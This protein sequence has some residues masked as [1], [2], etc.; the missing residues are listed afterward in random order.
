MT[1]ANPPSPAGDRR[2][3]RDVAK[4]IDRRRMRRRLT[5]WAVLLALVAAAAMYLRCGSGFGLGGLGEPG[6]G[7][8]A[9]TLTGQRRCAIRVTAKQITVDGVPRSR[10]AAVAAC[11]A[12]A[13]ADVVITGDAREGEWTALKAALVAAGVD[14]IVVHQKK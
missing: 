1:Q 4:Q 7:G 12:T 13:G 2:F 11:K 9:R 6:D 3:A 8:S 5:L 14:D 10:D